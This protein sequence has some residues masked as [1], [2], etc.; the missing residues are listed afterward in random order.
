MLQDL[1]RWILYL[2]NPRNFPSYWRTPSMSA[3]GGN[4]LHWE[5]ATVA[6]TACCFWLSVRFSRR[7][8]FGAAHWALVCLAPMFL[9]LFGSFWIAQMWVLWSGLSSTEIEDGVTLPAHV[10][11]A[12]TVALLFSSAVLRF[13]RSRA[14]SI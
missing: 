6:L 8:W 14:Q 13:H 9:G 12:C 1:Y 7:S 11:V 3:F 10:G 4:P 5:L 2:L